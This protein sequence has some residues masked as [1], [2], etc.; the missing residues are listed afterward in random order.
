VG[1]NKSQKGNSGNGEVVQ[2]RSTKG[3]RKTQVNIE[4]KLRGKWALSRRVWRGN[5]LERTEGGTKRNTS[6]RKTG[7]GNHKI[8]KGHFNNGK[9]FTKKNGGERGTKKK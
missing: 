2:K 3:Q 1:C 6:V 7:G 4:G 8:R 9:R 5:P